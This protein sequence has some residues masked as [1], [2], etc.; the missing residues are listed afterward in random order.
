PPQDEMRWRQRIIDLLAVRLT[1]FVLS[2]ASNRSACKILETTS[3]SLGNRLL[4]IASFCCQ[5]PEVQLR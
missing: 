2:E 1:G 5:L 3:G 4:A